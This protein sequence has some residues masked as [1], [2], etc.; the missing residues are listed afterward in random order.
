LFTF[1]SFKHYRKEKKEKK[2][3]ALRPE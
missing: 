3:A 2:L 1:D